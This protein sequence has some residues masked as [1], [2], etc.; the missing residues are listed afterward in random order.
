[1]KDR[2]KFA[3]KEGG[4]AWLF[5]LLGAVVRYGNNII[6]TRMLGAT[7]FGLYA[8]ANT[9]VTVASIA[10]SFGLPSAMVHFVAKEKE[11]EDY[12]SLVWFIKKGI[13]ITLIVSVS[14][15]V[16]FLLLAPLISN[17]IYKKDGLIIPLFGLG[18]SIPFLSLYNVKSSILQG[19]MRIRK[20]VFI[21]KIAHPLIFSILLLVGAFFLRRME[22][23]L[24]CYLL[25][26][27]IV[28]FIA[29]LW[30]KKEIKKIPPAEQLK[31][32]KYKELF[33]F[34]FPILFLNFLSFFILQSDILIMG[35]FREPKEVGI[36]AIASRLALGVG[37]PADSLGASLAPQYSALTGKNDFNGL[38]NL[39]K[40]STRWIFIT[41]AV[42]SIVLIFG[43]KLILSL[44][45]KDFKNGVI[46]LCILTSGQLF[47]AAFGTNGTLITQTG[48]PKINLFNA[49]FIGIFNVVVLLFMVP[50]YGAIGAASASAVSLIILNI[51]RSLEIDIILKISPWNKSIIKPLFALIVSFA[52]GYFLFNFS[53]IASLVASLAM[54]AL[55]LLV[56]GF[57]REDK[58][59]FQKILQKL[60]MAQNG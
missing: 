4:F 21:E 25:S 48:H 19:F 24:L 9:V 40:T 52:L 22:F 37:M 1:M 2:N 33:S 13:K 35:F 14:S 5:S 53:S 32:K 44:F 36:Y 59:M 55:L 60:K 50:K 43:S 3:A 11:R 57:E 20:R 38:S 30:I 49:I 15:T 58:E 29:Y 12:S 18:L 51:I 31:E 41:S 26:A 39:Y 17:N 27:A 42:V 34:S 7:N 6:L 45:G 46:A 47:S 28:F 8:L 54:F 16:L 56:M 23:V 10:T